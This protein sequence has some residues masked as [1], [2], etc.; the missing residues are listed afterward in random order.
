VK[1]R[2]RLDIVALIA[3]TS[4]L[5]ISVWGLAASGTEQITVKSADPQLSAPIPATVYRP[6]GAGPFPAVVLLHGCS[7][8]AP[9][10]ASWA[11]WLQAHGY[12]AIMPES[13]SPRHIKTSC[14][15]GLGFGLQAEDG[16]GALAYL[17]SQSYVIPTKV[18]V[19]GW[20]HGGAATLISDSDRFIK[21][22]SPE[23]GP[24]KAAMALYPACEA[25]R[26]GGIASPLLMLLGAADDWQPPAQCIARGTELK[27][28]G[29][30]IE[31]T[32]Y[33]GATHAFDEDAQTRTFQV[34]GHTVHLRYDPSATADAHAQ[35]ER[36]LNAHLQ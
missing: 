23:G 12:V 35:V 10:Q 32:V 27:S 4:V 29:A 14:G 5:G 21:Q 6:Q 17:R 18:F 11:S 30:P 20:S 26:G 1:I 34:N 8:I 22:L 9:Y 15:G 25:F 13:L 7:G 19:M 24:Y 2:V 36:F 16:L 28:A 3:I 33:P 31:W